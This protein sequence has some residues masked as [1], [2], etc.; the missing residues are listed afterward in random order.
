MVLSLDPVA[1]YCPGVGCSLVA[2]FGCH[3][4]ERSIKSFEIQERVSINLSSTR[5]VSWLLLTSMPI[6]SLINGYDVMG[7]N[8]E[9]S[10]TLS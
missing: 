2:A 6:S 9:H 7:A 10:T 1:V 8:A 4:E 5:R 3:L